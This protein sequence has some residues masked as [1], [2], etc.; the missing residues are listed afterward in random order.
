MRNDRVGPP[1][2]KCVSFD[3]A[4][5][6]HVTSVVTGAG[7]YFGGKQ[8]SPVPIASSLGVSEEQFGV[9]V[10]VT[11]AVLDGVATVSTS[12]AAVMNCSDRNSSSVF[13][14]TPEAHDDFASYA[15]ASPLPTELVLPP[16]PVE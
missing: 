9:G 3:S 5:V 14:F 15:F 7:T 6:N 2:C 13:S 10:A 12:I 4:V 11:T 16:V 1:F 8:G